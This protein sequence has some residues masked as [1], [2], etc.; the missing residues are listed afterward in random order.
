MGQIL[1]FAPPLS[2]DD[3]WERYASLARQVTDDHKFLYDREHQERMRDA[4]NAW[5]KLFD[6]KAGQ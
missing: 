1:D 4:Y 3:A 2:V 6:A 5:A